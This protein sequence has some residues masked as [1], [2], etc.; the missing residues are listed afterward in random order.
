MHEPTGLSV[1]GDA[2]RGRVDSED[3]VVIGLGNFSGGYNGEVGAIRCELELLF[4][5]E[6]GG[7]VVAEQEECFAGGV[8]G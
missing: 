5:E 8:I 7:G 3:I 1:E 6:G 4:G 2:D